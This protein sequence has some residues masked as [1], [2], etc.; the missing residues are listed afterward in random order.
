[1]LLKRS[2]A[3]SE[4][5]TDSE[6]AGRRIKH[7]LVLDA[8]SIQFFGIPRAMSANQVKETLNPK[9]LNILPSLF[10]VCYGSFFLM[11]RKS[12]LVADLKPIPFS[13]H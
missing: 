11:P 8:E 13:E 2:A 5:S 12:S 4:G 10:K 6:R 3:K 1:V 7:R 9:T